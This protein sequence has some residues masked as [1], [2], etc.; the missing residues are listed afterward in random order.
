LSHIL[1]AVESFS[2]EEKVEVAYIRWRQRYGMHES[3]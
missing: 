2:Y 3:P 1:G